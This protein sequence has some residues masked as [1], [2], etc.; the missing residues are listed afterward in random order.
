MLLYI[1]PACFSLFANAYE[2]V[3]PHL[4][5]G[6]PRRVNL[7]RRISTPACH[8]EKLGPYFLS[9][10]C[11]HIYMYKGTYTHGCKAIL[12]IFPQNFSFYPLV[13]DRDPSN[14]SL[15]HP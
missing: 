4:S 3:Y 2:F 6:P 11:I 5:A 14:H 12:V 7:P 10:F 13:D 15:H 8:K 1:I 9:Y